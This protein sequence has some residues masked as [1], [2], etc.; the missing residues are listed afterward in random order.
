MTFFSHL[1]ASVSPYFAIFAH[2]NRLCKYILSAFPV[3]L[4]AVVSCSHISRELDDIDHMLVHQPDSALVAI[5][6]I[7]TNK[8]VSTK[9]KA[10]YSLLHTMAIDRN[11]ADTTD[12]RL[13]ADAVKYYSH[14]RVSEDKVRLLFYQGRL[15]Y[16][17][18]DYSSAIQSFFA[19]LKAS[20][21][22]SN[23]WLKG[24]ICCY[25]SLTY[26]IDHNVKDQLDYQKKARD[27]FVQHGDETY[28]NNANY[29]LAIA[30]HN[31]R[32][33]D[34]ADSLFACIPPSSVLYP[35]AVLGRAHSEIT[36]P[37]PNNHERALAFFK[38]AQENKAPFSLDQWYQYAYTL[39]LN[40]ERSP[41]EQLT[42]KL[43][44]QPQDAKTY[45]WRFKIAKEKKDKSLALDYLEHY[46][47][48]SEK[49]VR[50][51]LSQSS[52]KAES[53]YY[54]ALARQSEQK[55]VR[56][57]LFLVIT[58][59][60][61][62]GLVLVIIVSKQRQIINLQ[63]EREALET[64]YYKIQE[65]VSLLNN[66]LDNKD[67][68]KIASL[69]SSYIS[70]YRQHFASIGNYIDKDVSKSAVPEQIE[71]HIKEILS[72][73]KDG[74]GNQDRFENRLNKDFDNIM[75]VIRK[76]FPDYSQ[77]TYRF[78]SYVIAGLRNTS[79]AKL[80]NES[81]TAIST[82][83]SRLKQQILNSDSPNKELYELFLG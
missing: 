12:Y 33:F 25:I 22:I 66:E 31:N 1:T 79:I 6:R 14:K 40:G 74:Q 63:R 13:L 61:A 20:E 8:L 43:D 47:Q 29:H 3:L 75:D 36:K 53:D 24:M 18:Q 71:N 57:Y 67:E 65:L 78:L 73:L 38:I 10:R 72:E 34:E 70:M 42:A 5:E 15:Y 28:I 81:T 35:S 19:A 58:I 69:R 16:N 77:E 7:D 9:M 21:A 41:S 56:S 11:G 52:Y 76:D 23:D 4:L 27:F 82:R 50:S 80:L 48:E 55:R 60:A 37:H 83:K 44:G 68:D 59:F 51:M 46:T 39:L 2:M 54:A 30:Y 17:N 26:A 62:I 45:W 49:Y 32:L 64:E